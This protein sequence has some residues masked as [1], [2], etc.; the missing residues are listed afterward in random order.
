MAKQRSRADRLI[1]F[2]IMIMIAASFALLSPRSHAQEYTRNAVLVD[3]T[4]YPGVYRVQAVKGDTDATIGISSIA[5]QN[6]ENGPTTESPAI[7]MGAAVPFEVKTGP[8]EFTPSDA[9]PYAPYSYFRYSIIEELGPDGTTHRKM[10]GFDGSYYIIRVDVSNLI[11]DA[12][13]GSFLHVKQEGN[14]AL[15]VSL[16][17]E[18]YSAETGRATFSDALGNKV[19]VYSIANDGLSMK[20]KAGNDSEKP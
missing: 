7:I 18:A 12:P 4:A 16:L 19:G 2:L 9:A 20:D 10:S 14:K 5:K 6:L 8:T 17:H 15:M 1:K 3:S 13:E 11:A